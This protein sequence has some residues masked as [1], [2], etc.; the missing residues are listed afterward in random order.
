MSTERSGDQQI[1]LVIS[2]TVWWVWLC[3]SLHMICHLHLCW[4]LS[5]LSPGGSRSVWEGTVSHHLQKPSRSFARHLLSS[6][7]GWVHWLY[8]FYLGDGCPYE[9]CCH[10]CLLGCGVNGH[11][12]PNGAAIPTG[13][14]CL[15]CTCEVCHHASNYKLGN[16]D[17]FYCLVLFYLEWKCGMFSPS[18]SCRVLSK[19]CSSRWRLLPTVTD[20]SNLISITETPTLL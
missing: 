10:V 1:I 15:E 19:P 17:A 6:L 4:Y 12:F 3:W 18:L 9:A 13:D 16:G 7:S 2:A 11:N 5:V 14:N 20:L 8:L